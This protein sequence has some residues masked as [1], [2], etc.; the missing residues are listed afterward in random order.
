VAL[1]AV[2]RRVATQMALLTSPGGALVAGAAL[3]ALALCVR[4]RGT[5]LRPLAE[6]GARPLAAGLVGAVV[7]T[8]AGALGND[9]PTDMLAIGTVLVVLA[10]GYARCAPSRSAPLVPGDEPL[11]RDRAEAAAAL[12]RLRHRRLV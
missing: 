12:T 5:V 11:H 2:E 6:R 10:A 3:S 9:S 4:H 8:A 1:A 7:A